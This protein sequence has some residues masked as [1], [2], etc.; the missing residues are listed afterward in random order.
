MARKLKRLR[1]ETLETVRYKDVDCFLGKGA[2]CW[3]ECTCPKREST[4]QEQEQGAI[5]A[6]GPPDTA[7]SAPKLK[8]RI[9]PPGWS[10]FTDWVLVR[11]KTRHENWAALNCKQQDM[12]TW[13]PRYIEPGKGTPQALFPGHLFVRPGDQW[14][15][16]RNTYGVIDIIMMGEN[17]DYVPKK[18]LRELRSR[19]D[20]DGIVT[21]PKQRKPEKGERVQIKVGAWQG[22]VG[23]Y[24][25]LSPDKRIRVLLSLFGREALLEFSRPSSIEIAD[26]L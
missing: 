4:A 11:T 24:D 26:A 8:R 1:H 18:V 12:E 7:P 23:L 20:K 10:P 25:G 17:P 5:V 19:A 9:R 16:L 2:C 14:K 15:K 13:L 22:F 3:P 6:G 21:L